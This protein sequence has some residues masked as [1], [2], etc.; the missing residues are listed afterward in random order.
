LAARLAGGWDLIALAA[1]AGA[2]NWYVARQLARLLTDGNRA[3]LLAELLAEGG[4]QHDPQSQLA[5]RW[6]GRR[7]R[8]PAHRQRGGLRT[9][10]HYQAAEVTRI[11]AL[12]IEDWADTRC[13][14]SA[15]ITS[16]AATL[17][18]ASP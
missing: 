5:H 14:P 8:R 1:R 11:A 13:R 16:R 12:P 6:V 9:R 17:L 15:V 18:Q 7:R 2:G 10:L 3:A 4:D